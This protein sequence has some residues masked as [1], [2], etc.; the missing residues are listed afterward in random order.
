MVDPLTGHVT[1]RPAVCL[2]HQ[3]TN[4]H[5]NILTRDEQHPNPWH[6]T[7][8][9]GTTVSAVI[10]IGY[11]VTAANVGDSSA[12]LDTGC[13]ILEL[14]GSHRIQ[15]NVDEQTRLRAAGCQLAPL[16]FHLQGPARPNEL[17]VGPLRLWPGGLCVSRSVGDLDAGPEVMPLPNIR[18]VCAPA[19]AC[20][21]ARINVCACACALAYMC[22]CM[23]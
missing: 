20:S 5:P 11:L 22:V 19:R 9:A 17:G 23:G 7:T 14:T 6:N 4:Q 10:V 2:I 12:V 1:G 13:S 18:Q 21:S 8:C 3:P 15:S 16:G